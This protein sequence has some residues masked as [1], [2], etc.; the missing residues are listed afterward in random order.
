MSEHTAN[1]EWTRNG[2][3]FQ[4]DRFSRAHHWSFEGGVVV[5]ASAAPDFHG[6]PKRV[7]PEQAFVASLSSCHMLTFLAI[8]ARKRFVVESYTDHAV[9]VLTKNERGKPWM[10]RVSLRPKVVFSGEKRPTQEEIAAL[11]RSAHENCFIAL[12]V[13][14][15]VVVE[16]Q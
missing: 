5:P 8:A 11:H 3:D 7:D 9:G 14:S 15:E 12:S 4:F 16:P 10:S 2:E 1:V 6:D 13:R